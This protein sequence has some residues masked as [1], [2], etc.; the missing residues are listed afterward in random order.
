MPPAKTD[1]K[2][3]EGRGR[4]DGQKLSKSKLYIDVCLYMILSYISILF[5]TFYVHVMS[6]ESIKV[7]SFTVNRTLII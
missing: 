6:Q 3:G 4:E 1:N 2:T 5:Q 7:K